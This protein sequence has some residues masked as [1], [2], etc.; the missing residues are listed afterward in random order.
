MGGAFCCG[1]TGIYLKA[2]LGFSMAAGGFNFAATRAIGVAGVA[3]VVGA[4]V[5][6]FITFTLVYLIL[7]DRVWTWLNYKLASI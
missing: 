4:T 6:V 3:G 5:G 7:W 2:P 1:A